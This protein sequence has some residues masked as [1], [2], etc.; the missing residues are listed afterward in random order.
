MYKQHVAYQR[1]QWYECVVRNTTTPM[2]VY[3]TDVAG[4]PDLFVFTPLRAGNAARSLRLVG[5]SASDGMVDEQVGSFKAGY[6]YGPGRFVV[7]VWGYT[8]S[9][10]DVKMW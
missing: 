7:A 2:D 9:T 1:V 5:Y 3:V 6:W 4:D 8:T 10:Y